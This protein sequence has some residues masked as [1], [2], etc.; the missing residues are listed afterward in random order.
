[1]T[2][3]DLAEIRKMETNTLIELYGITFDTI[4]KMLLEE[5]F[6]L[7]GIEI[8]IEILEPPKEYA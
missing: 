7:R 8:P 2:V 4:Q 5:I 6:R 1:M 3:E